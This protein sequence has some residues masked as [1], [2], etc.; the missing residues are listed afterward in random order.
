MARIL[1]GELDNT[2]LGAATLIYRNTCIKNSIIRREAVIEEDVELE[3]CIIMDYVRV[4]KGARLRNVIID[5]HNV[6]ETGTV[7]GHDLEQDMH[8]YTVTPG[9]VVVVPK[10]EV[11]IYA[12]DSRGNGPGYAE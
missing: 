4:K 7:L 8:G 2:L 11:N 5:R 9:G 10:G 12:R 1:G 3:N 6:I